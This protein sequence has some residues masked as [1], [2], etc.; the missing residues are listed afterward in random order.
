MVDSSVPPR[1]SRAQALRFTRVRLRNWRNFRDAEVTLGRRAFLVGP[2]ASGKSNLLDALRF[3]R[4]I[5]RPEG[6]L[7][8][9]LGQPGRGDFK[10]VRCLFARKPSDLV[11]DVDVGTDDEP[12]AW[13]YELVLNQPRG[14]NKAFVTVERERVERAGVELFADERPQTNPDWLSHTQTRIEQ[15]QRNQEFREL[16]EFFTSMRYLHLVPQIVRDSRRHLVA[17]DDP[18]GGDLLLPMKAIPPKSRDPRLRRIAEALKI[19]VPNFDALRL[20]DDAGGRPHLEADFSNWRPRP[21]K[22]TEDLLSDGSL[23][24]IGFLWSITERGG[25]LLLEEPELSL[26]DEVVAQLPAMIAR[27]QHLSGRQVIA[28]THSL[29]MLDAPGVGLDEVHRIVPGKDGSRIETASANPQVREQVGQHGWTIGQALLPLTAPTGI[30]KL[31]KTPL[32]A[33]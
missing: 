31:A 26:H 28:S 18:F 4:D 33:D 32:V 11:L 24:L 8:W 23:R 10:N 22:H 30:D 25:P 21:T 2:N 3:L 13:R 16:A 14:S 27:A 7:Q 19:A 17:G 20:E 15:V 12:K 6:G 1:R 29:R 5:A 9:A